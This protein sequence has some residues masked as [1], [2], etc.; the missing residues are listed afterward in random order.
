MPLKIAFYPGYTD[1]MQNHVFDVGSEVSKELG[2]LPVINRY[3]ALKQYLSAR[4]IEINT[5]DKYPNLRE[6]DLWIMMEPG[7]RRYLFILKHSI[8]PRKVIFFILEPKIV[9]P[10]GWKYLPL[11]RHFHKVFLSWSSD[12]AKKY[13]EQFVEF[14]VPVP[15]DASRYPGFLESK[16]KNL[17]VLMQSNKYSSVPGELYSLRRKIIRYFEHRGDHILDL[18]GPGWNTEDVGKMGRN[19]TPFHA[20]CYKGFASDKWQT[21]SEYW[22]A[23]CIQNSIPAG[24]FEYD[25]FMAMA[26]GTVPIF[27]PPP[28]AD[29][30][31]PRDTYVNFA[32]FPDWDDLVKYLQSFKGT[33]E[34]E[35]MRKR[36]WEYLNSEKYRPFTT[37]KFCE[38][39]HHAIMKALA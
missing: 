25:P 19:V 4:G 34:Y 15:F 23:F 27:L 38:N 5:Y 10:W 36:G 21:F 1:M 14:K 9:N 28:N 35:A 6:I 2:G 3:A 26:T 7:I 8:N 32:D 22:F 11:Y 31:I 20:D 30:Y 16:K 39:V 18:Y 24:D 33:K 17:C 13:P 12:L 29:E 37:E